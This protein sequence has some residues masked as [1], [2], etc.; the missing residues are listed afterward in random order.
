MTGPIADYPAHLTVI[1][2]AVVPLPEPL[3]AL[4]T[5]LKEYLAAAAVKD[6][7]VVLGALAD[8]RN[9]IAGA[10]ADAVLPVR[11]GRIPMETVKT[12]LGAS[13]ACREEGSTLRS[14]LQ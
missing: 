8:L 10:G 11:V 6:P 4:L 5:V 13:E 14:L 7:L 1:R 3:I 12:V 9:L 2:D